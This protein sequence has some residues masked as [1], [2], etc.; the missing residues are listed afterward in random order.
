MAKCWQGYCSV[1]LKFFYIERIAIDFLSSW[2]HL[3]KGEMY[4]DWMIRD[5]LRYLKNKENGFI[6][7]PGTYRIMYLGDAW[8][9]RTQS[10]IDR[11]VKACAFELEDR[12]IAASAEWQKIFGLDF[13]SS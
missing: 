3:H 9:S 2:E 11:A 6:V 1:P 10:A 12:P 5:F 4:Y 13:P 8:V 7:L